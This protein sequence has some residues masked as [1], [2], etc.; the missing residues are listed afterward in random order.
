M[1]KRGFLKRKRAGRMRRKP[2]KWLEP[3]QIHQDLL[4]FSAWQQRTVNAL[5]GI[6]KLLLSLDRFNSGVAEVQAA[7][8]RMGM[9]MTY[10]A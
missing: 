2:I 5:V 7:R 10:I 1:N 9:G 6:P 8:D 4:N 3:P